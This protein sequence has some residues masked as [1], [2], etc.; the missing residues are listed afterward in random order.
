MKVAPWPQELA[1]HYRAQGLWRGETF[2]DMLRSRA[3]DPQVAPRTAVI[4]ATTGLTYAELDDHVARLAAG[5]VALGICG[6]ALAVAAGVLVWDGDPDLA[7]RT[8]G[9]IAYAGGV[10][11]LVGVSAGGLGA[12]LRLLDA[13][14]P[15]RRE[16]ERVDLGGVG[17][18]E[19]APL[20]NQP[21]R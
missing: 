20:R 4:D 3:A 17:T 8:T 21:S 12:L 5:L 13:T 16:R 18:S 19:P 1:D 6:L 10:A 11:A 2:D 7:D 14:R 9:L 15:A